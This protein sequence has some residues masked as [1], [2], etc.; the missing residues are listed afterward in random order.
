MDHFHS[1]NNRFVG[2][3]SFYELHIQFV[4]CIQRIITG[5]IKNINESIDESFYVTLNDLFLLIADYRTSG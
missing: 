5:Y 2:M 3:I 1:T 4:R